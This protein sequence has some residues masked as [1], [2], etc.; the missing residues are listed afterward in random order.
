[1]TKIT[2]ENLYQTYHERVERFFL[3]RTGSREDAEDLTSEVF[4]KATRALESFDTNKASL[5]TWIY[6]ISR[7]TLTDHLRRKK[8][9]EEYP[10]LPYEEDLAE[11]RIMQ[12]ETLRELA[13]ALTRLD[14]DQ[15]DIVILHYYNGL[16]LTE[17][18]RMM[19]ISYGAVKL[20][21]KKAL[22]TLN[23][24]LSQEEASS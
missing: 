7:N 11:K 3:S 1:M 19:H 21:H 18:A 8:T 13:E 4:L 23:L 24:S 16:T 9:A 2:A 15:R 10:E 22:K 12:E 20:R 6:T 17:I 14:R 5:S